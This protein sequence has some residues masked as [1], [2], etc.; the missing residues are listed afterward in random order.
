MIQC[1]TPAST[2]SGIPKTMIPNPEDTMTELA[3]A[4][5]ALLSD[6]LEYERVNKLFAA[7]VEP[8]PPLLL[9]QRVVER[10]EREL[11]RIERCYAQ[12]GYMEASDLRA[13]LSYCQSGRGR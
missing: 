1:N 6:V 10:V 12:Y 8:A 11:D 13:L 7:A 5:R 3:N 2:F 4:L 9:D